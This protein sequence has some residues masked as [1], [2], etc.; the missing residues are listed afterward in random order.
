MKRTLLSAILATALVGISAAQ[1]N[2]FLPVIGTGAGAQ[3]QSMRAAG[4]LPSGKFLFNYVDL[5]GQDKIGIF[6]TTTELFTGSQAGNLVGYRVLNTDGATN[7]LLIN[8]N[9]V[10]NLY[11]WWDTTTDVIT[12]ITPQAVGV[13]LSKA[14]D[15][16]FYRTTPSGY[17]SAYAYN[18]ATSTG[19]P[20]QSA[21]GTA[22]EVKAVTA[23]NQA[24]FTA[25]S[26]GGRRAALWAGT[27]A[28]HVNLH[29]TGFLNSE[30]NGI[31]AG[32]QYGFARTLAKVPNAGYWAG[33]AGSFVNLHQAAFTETRASSGDG[34]YQAGSGIATNDAKWRVNIWKGTAARRS[35]AMPGTYKTVDTSN[36][37]VW[38]GGGKVWVAAT[39]YDGAKQGVGVWY[40]ATF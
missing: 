23:G 9:V 4:V 3:Y 6:D 33:T 5:S 39:L 2:R 21:A 32:R 31:S 14:G 29:P 40:Y 13:L 8:R 35:I 16:E 20:L 26:S 36:N 17:V 19:A 18:T 27:E 28:S 12:D 37:Y 15:L 25:T 1:T 34:T 22:S 10:P 30:A 7:V 24:G 38:A 11:K